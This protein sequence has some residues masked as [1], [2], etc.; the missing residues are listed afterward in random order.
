MHVR[1]PT[2]P[3]SPIRGPARL[4]QLDGRIAQAKAA[5]DVDSLLEQ[6]ELGIG[7]AGERSSRNAL[8]RMDGGSLPLGEGR[9]LIFPD[10]LMQPSDRVAL[11]GPNGSG[12]STLLR[13]MVET[14]DLEADRRIYIPQEITAEQSIAIHEAARAVPGDRL[15]E[16]MSW[17]RRLGSDPQRVLDSALPSPGEIRKLLLA[18][19]IAL[20]PCLI[21]MDEPTN[22]MD[23]PSIECVEEVLADCA[24]GLLLVSHDR[25]L[26]DRLTEIVWSIET[27][28]PGGTAYELKIRLGRRATGG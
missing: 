23:L 6:N 28:D 20:H 3:A 22:H 9:S 16:T 8:V 15:G 2:P 4:R 26:L 1:R 19:K 14:N 5:Q 10:L 7:I 11:V 18:T 12:K 17:V 21:I 13:R 27:L 25:P 24:S